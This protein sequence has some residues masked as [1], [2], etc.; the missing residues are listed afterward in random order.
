M[1]GEI[2]PRRGAGNFM[3]SSINGGGRSVASAKVTLTP[4]VTQ[5]VPTHEVNRAVGLRDLGTIHTIGGA[6][7][8]GQ[9]I[10]KVVP[11]PLGA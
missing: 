2:G 5:P 3:K 1:W 9:R 8:E 6:I 4:R 11:V 7:G 10:G